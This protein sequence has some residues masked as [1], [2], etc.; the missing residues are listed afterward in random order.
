MRVA[1]HNKPKELGLPGRLKSHVQP[2]L[3]IKNVQTGSKTE[4]LHNSNSDAL[5]QRLIQ[6]SLGFPHQLQR[7]VSHLFVKKDNNGVCVTSRDILQQ[8]TAGNTLKNG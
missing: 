7:G 8:T 3:Q 2:S 4:T 5:K 1:S 6:C